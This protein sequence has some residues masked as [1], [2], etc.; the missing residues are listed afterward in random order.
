MIGLLAEDVRCEN[1][2]AGVVTVASDGRGAFRRLAEQSKALFSEC[3]QYPARSDSS[4]AHA[5]VGIDCLDRRPRTFH[6]DR[7]PVP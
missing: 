6:E 2:S 1:P 7:Q 3:G 4:P 5:I